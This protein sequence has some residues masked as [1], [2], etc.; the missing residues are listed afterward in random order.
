MIKIRF[1][2][3]I[4]L[5]VFTLISCDHTKVDGIVIDHTLYE[6][7]TFSS[8]IELK[9]L[10]RQALNKDENALI[11]L[12]SFWCGGAAGCYDLGF[13]ITQII[14]RLG[15]DEFIKMVAKLNCNNL[16]GFDGL[17]EVGL[18]YGDNNKDGKI[19]NKS[20]ESVFP[21]LNKILSDKCKN[22]RQ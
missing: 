7:L 22:Q 5:F 9:K 14:Y 18:L 21:K 11:K 1:L 12:N 17:I 20:I 3:S 16:L 4:S 15:E 19:D 8:Q 6:N 2:L 13:V 10:I